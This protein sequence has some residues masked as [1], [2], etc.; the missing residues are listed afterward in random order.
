[1]RSFARAAIAFLESCMQTEF[2][3]YPI[4]IKIKKKYHFSSMVTS[5]L[6]LYRCKKTWPSP[7]DSDFGCMNR[8]TMHQGQLERK[9]KKTIW[10]I[11]T[12]WHRSLLRVHRPL[13]G[14]WLGNQRYTTF[15]FWSPW[16]L[17]FWDP[18]WQIKVRW[19]LNHDGF[20]E[21]VDLFVRSFATTWRS[22]GSVDYRSDKKT[23]SIVGEY[24]LINL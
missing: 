8:K 13:T 19:W 9:T 11:R 14:I 16:P 17:K 18:W 3:F 1:M 21:S 15:G 24:A 20:L 4:E 5:V 10:M 22:V 2:L 7:F 23:F 12:M 6:F